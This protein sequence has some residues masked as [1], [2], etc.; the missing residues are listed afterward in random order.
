MSIANFF[1]VPSGL[2]ITEFSCK[3]G[4]VYSPV[5]NIL[6]NVAQGDILDVIALGA[7][8]VGGPDSGARLPWV[9]G[10]FYT[11]LAGL[12]PAALLTVAST[13]YAV[14]VRI[15]SNI[16]VQT[17]S[18]NVTT[19][20]TGGKVRFGIYTDLAGV[21]TS[22]IAG[23]DSGDQ[24]A[25]GTAAATLTPA[26]PI[27]L[28]DGWYWLALTATASSTMPSVTGTTANAALELSRDLGFDTLAH[29]V[30][31]SGEFLG[32]VSAAFTYGAL[33]ATFPTA[34]YALGLNAAAPVIFIGT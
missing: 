30:A 1:V 11:G 10:R 31:A 32:G 2:N 22:L 23:S 13:I 15:P 7:R 14:P 26:A 5:N 28:N 18:A 24:V 29:A 12:T 4:N 6:T 8:Q 19:G 17:I 34:S 27:S 9:A 16:P 25:T 20:Q 21:P 3:S 33:P